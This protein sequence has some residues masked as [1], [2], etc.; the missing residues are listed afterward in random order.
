MFD[1][2]QVLI[3][4]DAKGNILSKSDVGEYAYGEDRPFAVES[5]KVD[6]SLAALHE[7][8]Q[9]QDIE[10]TPFQRVESIGQVRT[11]DGKPML[12]RAEFAYNPDLERM[13]MTT[14][15]GD[16]PAETQF[17]FGDYEE[18]QIDGRTVQYCYVQSPAG[19]LAVAVKSPSGSTELYYA[20]TDY[21]G[22]IRALVTGDGK[23]AERFEFDPWGRRRNPYTHQPLNSDEPVFPSA[24]SYPD[25]VSIERGFCGQEHLDDFDLINLNA[26]LYD[27]ILGR[28]LS[29][30]PFVQQ[31]DNTQNLN[32]YAYALNNSFNYMDPSGT[33][34]EG[35]IAWGV[36]A[37]AAVIGGVVNVA[38]HAKST[39]YVWQDFANFGIG[40]LISGISSMTGYGIAGLADKAGFIWGGLIGGL[41][42]AGI[43]ALTSPL[44]T[45]LNNLVAGSPFGRN[46]GKNVTTD[47]LMGFFSGFISGSIQGVLKAK[48]LGLSW[49]DG[50]KVIP[51]EYGQL[52]GFNA[53]DFFKTPDVE[54]F[55][56]Y[57]TVANDAKIKDPNFNVHFDRLENDIA[58]GK[59][60]PRNS[61]DKVMT[62]FDLKDEGD[63]VF[64][65][66]NP[67][68]LHEIGNMLNQYGRAVEHTAIN[69]GHFRNLLGM[70]IISRTNI[71][72]KTRIYVKMH[73]WDS[74]LG[75]FV[76]DF[77][78][79]DIDAQLRSI[80]FLI[81][82]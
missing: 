55:C 39:T 32:R 8:L 6:A 21:L 70:K 11:M 28:F 51:Y 63:F 2:A 4:Y 20:A 72:G 58:L 79:P 71:F 31:P 41:S 53:D 56:S 36:V 42:G 15:V 47:I 30:D 80:Y 45:G 65:T 1:T 57:Y 16:K 10:Y 17:Y 60:N 82:E 75:R 54:S 23:V 61:I 50:A 67:R 68:G 49:W 18:K 46:M 77:F 44:Q 29:P 5:I 3:E 81:N 38:V 19:L 76:N 69:D 43:A 12:V 62:Y 14:T 13:T 37:F 34:I 22:S 73:L 64:Q 27:P 33:A 24:K 25:I 48:S 74:N 59:A 52:S 9:N 35:F 40:F 26:R 66:L 78:R 7:R